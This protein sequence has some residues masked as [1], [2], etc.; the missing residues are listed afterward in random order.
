MAQRYGGRYSP[1]A[2]GDTGGARPAPKSPFAGQRRTRAGGRV[3]LLFL[4]PVPLI[5]RAF[6]SEPVQMAQ[7]LV[8]FGVL[9]LAAWLTREG[10]IAQEAYDARKIAKRPALPRKMLASVLTGLGLAI[11]GFAGH[12]AVEAAIFAVLGAGLHLFAFGPDPMRD[13]GAEG[14]DAFQSDRVARA[15]DAAEAHL[16]A[17]ADAGLRAKDREVTRRI[18]QFQATAREMFRMVEE[19]PRDLA[20]ARKFLGIYLSAARDATVKFA[21][22][23]A[24]SRDPQVKRDYFRLLDELEGNFDAKTQ[25]L[26]SN[27]RADL[28][29]E[30]EVLR[31]LLAREGLK[32]DS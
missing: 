25:K 17:M 31:D 7:Y 16:A 14:I 21:D 22:L 19:D 4:A 29:I 11:A 15:V 23:Y 13:K 12:G 10:I 3:N 30:M 2:E 5:W 26:L 1:E 32:T 6:T 27:N 9:I 28:D 8:A 20:G 24:S 18:E